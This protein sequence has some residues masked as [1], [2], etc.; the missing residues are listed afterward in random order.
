M[1]KL[2]KK[3]KRALSTDEE[4]RK[5]FWLLQRELDK[6]MYESWRLVRVEY[7]RNDGVCEVLRVDEVITS[8][9]GFL[10]RVS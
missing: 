7:N 6:Q 1:P 10:L 4:L 2:L 9:S 8:P 3:V 5:Y